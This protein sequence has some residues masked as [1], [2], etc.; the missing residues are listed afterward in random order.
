MH[1]LYSS[2]FFLNVFFECWVYGFNT[3][4]V[5]CTYDCDALDVMTFVLMIGHLAKELETG[6]G[7][8]RNGVSIRTVNLNI[9]GTHAAHYDQDYVPK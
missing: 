4:D 9:Y 8:R 7:A 5:L 6:Q 1:G 3:A 2:V